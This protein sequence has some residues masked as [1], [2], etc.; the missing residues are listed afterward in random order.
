MS[1]RCPLQSLTISRVLSQLHRSMCSFRPCVERRLNSSC[2]NGVKPRRLA[3]HKLDFGTRDQPNDPKRNV[4]TAPSIET[5]GPDPRGGW[6]QQE[7]R[8][9][10]D[11]FPC[12]GETHLITDLPTSVGFGKAN[13]H[14]RSVHA[15]KENWRGLHH[16]R[17]DSEL[18]L[19]I[20]IV[21]ALHRCPCC[22]TK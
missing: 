3:L 7:S 11:Q 17:S 20:H 2:D 9:Q 22:C 12:A 6:V 18:L 14:G 19:Q 4:R 21:K 10:H 8:Q 16:T 15:S 5:L 1:S 13:P